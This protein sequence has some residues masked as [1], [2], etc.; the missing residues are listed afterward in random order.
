MGERGRRQRYDQGGATPTSAIVSHLSDAIEEPLLTQPRASVSGFLLTLFLAFAIFAI[1]AGSAKYLFPRDGG[2]Q[3]QQQQQ[4]AL[5]ANMET[6]YTTAQCCGDLSQPVLMG[7]DLVAYFSLE[8]D[9]GA[10]FGVWEYQAMYGGYRFV[11]STEENKAL[12][13]VSKAHVSK[14]DPYYTS[15]LSVCRIVRRTRKQG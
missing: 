14:H 9:E 12:F 1:S 10:I 11:F 6:S 8:E 2:G 13:E 15:G 5:D 3:Q 4:V 7:A